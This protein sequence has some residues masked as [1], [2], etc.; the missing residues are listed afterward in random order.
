[1]TRALKFA[2]GLLWT[3]FPGGSVVKKPS[4]GDAG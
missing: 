3:G 2:F 1:M 4:A